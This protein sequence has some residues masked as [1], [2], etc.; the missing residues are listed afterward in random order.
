MISK[1]TRT[2]PV[3]VP[4]QLVTPFVPPKNVGETFAANGSTYFTRRPK[5]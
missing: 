3:Q 2:K 4:N 5:F 1:M